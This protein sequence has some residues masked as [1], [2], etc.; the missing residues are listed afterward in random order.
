MNL[1]GVNSNSPPRVGG[2]AE[3]NKYLSISLGDNRYGI[4]VLRIREIIEY[5]AITPV[6]MMPPFVRGSINLRG[7]GVPVIDL[8]IR[9]GRTE[10]AI[11]RRTCIVIVETGADGSGGDMVGLLVDAVNEVVDLDSAEIEPAPSFGG[12]LRIEFMRGMAKVKGEFVI[13]L[14][15]D[16]VLAVDEFTQ[17]AQVLAANQ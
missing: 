16:R 11:I 1:A 9:F 17:A 5:A 10:T 6:P 14:D 12:K 3:L 7:R 8:A 13:L 2:G 4:E 15:V